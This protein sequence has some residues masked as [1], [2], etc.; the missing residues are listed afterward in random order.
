VAILAASL[1]PGS[2]VEAPLVT[3]CFLPFLQMRG[4][5]GNLHK[6]RAREAVLG[7]L[8]QGLQVRLED[9]SRAEVDMNRAKLLAQL[10]EECCT[11]PFVLVC[12]QH[13]RARHPLYSQPT[14]KWYIRSV[15]ISRMPQLS[16]A[17]ARDC[18]G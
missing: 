18:V 3:D 12:A 14:L 7:A 6:A 10:L 4:T 2:A 1:P 5:L 16:S 17:V 13:A 8:A 15:G 9:G 11:P